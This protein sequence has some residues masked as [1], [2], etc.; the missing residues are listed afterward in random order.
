MAGRFVYGKRRRYPHML[1]EDVAVWER[2]VGKFPGRFDS[3]DY[4]W[5]VGDG[6]AVDPE[7][8][9]A[10]VRMARMLSQ[11]RID[12]VGWNGGAATIVE[13]KDR[14]GLSAL[15]QVEGYR[16]LFVRDFPT[17]GTPGVLLVCGR[18]SPDDAA[19]M[20]RSGI[21]VEVV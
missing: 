11:K 8:D 10:Y 7:W 9:E 2:F 12:V 5:R 1:G 17:L 16:I 18:I 20:V 15:G 21:P 14:A 4:D 19:V 3:V 13:V 6:V